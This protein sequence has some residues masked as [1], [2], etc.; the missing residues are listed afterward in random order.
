MFHVKHIS[1]FIIIKRYIITIYNYQNTYNK[2][3][4]YHFKKQIQLFLHKIINIVY[5]I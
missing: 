5:I 1:I 4:Y 2:N 3:I